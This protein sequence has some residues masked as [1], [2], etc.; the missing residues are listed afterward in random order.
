MGLV[1]TVVA[2]PRGNRQAL[3]VNARRRRGRRRDQGPLRRP[4]RRDHGPRRRDGGQPA[5]LARPAGSE[6][7][8]PAGRGAGPGRGKPVDPKLEVPSEFRQNSELVLGQNNV[9][10]WGRSV[11][12]LAVA[13]TEEAPFSIEVVEPRSPGPGRLDGPQVIAKRKPV[14]T[15]P[16]AISLPGTRRAW[17]PRAGSRSPRRPTRP[18]SRSTPTAAPRFRPGRSSS[19]GPPAPRGADHGLLQLAK[20]TIA[21]QFLTLAYQP[22]SVEQGQETD[23]VV[24]VNKAV[25]FPGEA[26]VTL[27]GLPNKVT[28][29]AK[30][31]TKD[32]KELVFRI[33]TDKSPR[34]QPP[35]PVLP[36]GRDPGRRADRPQPRLGPLRIDVPLPPK[37][38]P[39]AARAVAAAPRPKPRRPGAGEATRPGSRSS[40]SRP[41]TGQG[42]PA[43]EAAP[44]KGN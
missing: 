28:T 33:K 29:D 6:S 43:G 25:N 21:G 42:P 10:Y 27:I 17:A 39:A 23:L 15:A 35:E 37:P 31:I 12:R 11:D 41:R 40:A 26:Q 4:S 36:G 9:Q 44:G 32:T 16:I 34:R 18:P 8:R 1:R 5:H 13:V 7:R 30:T 3:L 2:V 24:A 38:K 19:T 22:A 20:L 14:F